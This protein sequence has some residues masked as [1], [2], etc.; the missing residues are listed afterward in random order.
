[1][2]SSVRVVATLCAAVWM[3]GMITGCSAKEESDKKSPS[4]VAVK[5]NKE[6]IS[7]HQVNTLLS[8]GGNIPQDQIGR[9]RSAAVERLVDQE[10]L[11]Q[12]ALS[13]K[14]DRNPNVMQT[15][16][17]SRREILARAYSEQVMGGAVQPSETQVNEFF[18]KNPELF[19][20]RRI[21]DLRE[22]SLQI[23]PERFDEVRAQ[24]QS[25]GNPQ[26]LTTWFNEQKIPF[27]VNAGVKPAEQIPLEILKNLAQLNAGQAA[28]A[29]TP[30]GAVLIFVVGV[31]DEPVDRNTAKPVIQNF[32]LN[33]ARAES[34]RAEIKRLREASSINYVGEFA[35]SATESAAPTEQGPVVSPD[36]A[37]E[38]SI[39]SIMDK[40]AIRLR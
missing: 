16:D 10:L 11:L 12:Q 7:V 32:L 13:S 35:P 37:S 28:F 2:T 6:E 18:D 36:A 5:V 33:Q 26:Q 19:S 4:Q 9:A 3:T 17:F 15:I 24:V 27:A 20:K 23:P 40:G 39:Q 34:M 30:T 8:R 22:I 14:L 1:M 25:S 29:R 38:D 31:R 21:Y